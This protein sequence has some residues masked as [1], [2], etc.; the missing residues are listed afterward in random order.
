MRSGRGLARPE[1]KQFVSIYFADASGQFSVTS[2]L[3][4][5]KQNTAS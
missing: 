4:P 1:V 5:V 3:F 2:N